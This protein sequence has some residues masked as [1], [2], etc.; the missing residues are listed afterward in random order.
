MKRILC[1]V[2]LHGCFLAVGFLLFLALFRTPLASSQ[3]VF[4]YRGCRLIAWA[5]LVHFALMLL[6]WTAWRRVGGDLR[7]L[8]SNVAVA[9]CLNLVFF[10]HLPV[11][12]DR[13][14]TVMLLGYLAENPDRRVSP[15]ELETVFVEKFVRRDRAIARRLKEQVE[16]GTI[17]VTPDGVQ[18]TAQGEQVM[19]RY[20]QIA[21][22]FELDPRLIQPSR[23]GADPSQP[24]RKE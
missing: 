15:A 23:I 9:C 6:A 4:F 20:G 7:D 19:K 13:S 18:I 8:F 5:G 21:R 2:A 12:A 10:T 11:T 16:S 3:Q 14:V 22:F 24:A 17:T 1:L